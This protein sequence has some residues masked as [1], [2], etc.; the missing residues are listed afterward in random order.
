MTESEAIAGV[1]LYAEAISQP[2]FV[3][4]STC[5]SVLTR[6]GASGVI[7]PHPDGVSRG[8]IELFDLWPTHLDTQNACISYNHALVCC[9]P[10][11]TTLQYIWSTSGGPPCGVITERSNHWTTSEERDE[12]RER[13]WPEVRFDDSSGHILLLVPETKTSLVLGIDTL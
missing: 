10:E 7:V 8:V 4:D 1:T 5:I 2:Y 13:C 12:W 11:I 6:N 9:W 3:R